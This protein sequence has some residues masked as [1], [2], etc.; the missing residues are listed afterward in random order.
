MKRMVSFDLARDLSIIGVVMAHYQAIGIQPTWIYLTSQAFHTFRQALF[1]FASGYI[2][3]MT[4]KDMP[5]KAYI[6][7]KNKTIS[8]TIYSNIN[9]SN[10]TKSPNWRQRM[11]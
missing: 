1:M 11:R 4:K 8:G 10:H 5:Y 6:Q 2:Y 9:H 3:I 7:K